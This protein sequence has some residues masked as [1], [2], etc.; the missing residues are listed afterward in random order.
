[1]QPDQDSKAPET[2]QSALELEVD[3]HMKTL[4]SS[5]MGAFGAEFYAPTDLPPWFRHY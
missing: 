2:A 5:V 4:V 3:H 1:V